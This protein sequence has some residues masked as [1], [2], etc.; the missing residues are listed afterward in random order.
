MKDVKYANM[1]TNLIDLARDIR[2][3]VLSPTA[4]NNFL[5]PISQGELEYAKFSV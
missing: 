4:C 3:H 1:K 2:S 5:Y